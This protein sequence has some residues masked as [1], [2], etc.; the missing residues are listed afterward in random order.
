MPHADY[1]HRSTVDKLGIKPGQ[2]VALV[3]HAFPL[4][5]MLCREVRARAGEADGSDG[6]VD[7]VLISVDAATDAAAMLRIWR[8]RIDPAGGIWLLTPKRG[9]AGYVNQT[10]LI[11]AGLA[12]ELVDIKICS[13]SETVSGM[14]FVIRR[15]D[16]TL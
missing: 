6:P 9:Q 4:D 3:D 8:E 10:E 2:R 7:V 15:R 5:E 1:S 13:V 14:R 12:A 11:G 16:R